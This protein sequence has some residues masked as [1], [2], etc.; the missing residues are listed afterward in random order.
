MKRIIWLLLIGIMSCT[1]ICQA[2]MQVTADERVELTT[3]VARLTGMSG[4]VN[5]DVAAYATD[6][7]NRRWK[8]YILLT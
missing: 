5:N 3:I 8:V 2:Q 7:G 4:F 6:I 1:N